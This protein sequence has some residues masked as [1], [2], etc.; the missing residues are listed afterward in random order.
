MKL[1][2]MQH[3]SKFI[4]LLCSLNEAETDILFKH[5][6]HLRE[7]D[8]SLKFTLWQE[9]TR[10]NPI[11]IWNRKNEQAPGQYRSANESKAF[12]HRQGYYLPIVPGAEIE[13]DEREMDKEMQEA[14][15]RFEKDPDLQREQCSTRC[16]YATEYSCFK[17]SEENEAGHL[18]HLTEHIA[19][20]SQDIGLFRRRYARTIFK[21]L[22]ASD[23]LQALAAC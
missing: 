5:T 21:H 6:K 4:I 10:N 23:N 8:T 7:N 19:D 3:E 1:T 22:N 9:S 16:L 11:Y 2:L 18:L 12:A 17:P 20:V 13:D 14:A 15:K